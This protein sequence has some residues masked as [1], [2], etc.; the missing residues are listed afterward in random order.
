MDVCDDHLSQN[1]DDRE[2]AYNNVLGISSC[3]VVNTCYGVKQSCHVVSSCYGII[4]VR[5]E[6]SKGVKD[7]VKQA[8]RAASLKLGPETSN[9]DQLLILKNILVSFEFSTGE[10]QY[11]KT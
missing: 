10:V 6:R 11:V 3:H 9:K 8:R 4:F 1:P 7:E 5:L 2:T